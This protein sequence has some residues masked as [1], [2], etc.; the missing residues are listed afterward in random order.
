MEPLR[1]AWLIWEEGIAISASQIGRIFAANDECPHEDSGWLPRL[2]T[3]EFWDHAAD[4]CGLYLALPENAVGLSIS[5]KTGVQAKHR[6]HPTTPALKGRTSRREFKYCPPQRCP[7]QR[8]AARRALDVATRKVKRKTS[9]ATTWSPSSRVWRRSTRASR[10]LF[11]IH[12]VS[13]NGSSHTSKATKAWFAKHLRFVIHHPRAREVDHQADCFFRSLP[14]AATKV[15]RKRTEDG[16]ALHSSQGLLDHLATLT[17]NACTV[18]R[19]KQSFEQLTQPTEIQ[20]RA[21]ELIGA[22]IPLHLT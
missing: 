14:A 9:S 19:T 10:R 7:P 16:L 18:H 20:R 8:C 5:K 12:V 17:R 3:P 4:V 1:D 13:H 21:F 2:D 15:A 6:K 22:T 11:S